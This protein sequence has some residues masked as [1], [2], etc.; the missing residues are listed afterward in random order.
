MLAK[1]IVVEAMAALSTKKRDFLCFV[2][3]A[4]AA[5]LLATSG[6]IV[7]GLRMA[8]WAVKIYGEHNSTREA[9]ACLSRRREPR[10]AA[11]GEINNVRWLRYRRGKMA[12]RNWHRLCQAHLARSTE[13]DVVDQRQRLAR[14]ERRAPRSA[15][16]GAGAFWPADVAAAVC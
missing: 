9:S 2:C 8:T 3:Y 15:R 13:R 11:C 10:L 12:A 16:E 5:I 14:N 4:A 1:L 7:A 6:E